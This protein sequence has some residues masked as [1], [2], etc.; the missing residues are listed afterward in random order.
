MD[1]V[2]EIHYSVVPR[3]RI[4]SDYRDQ[5][6]VDYVPREVSVTDYYAVEHVR[7]YIPQIIPVKGIEYRPFQRKII[8]N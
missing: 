2:D 8:K 3:K 4:I 1:Y 7:K 5:V 6:R